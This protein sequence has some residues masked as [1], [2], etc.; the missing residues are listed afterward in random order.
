MLCFPHTSNIG[1]NFL[2][3]F[4][5]NYLDLEGIVLIKQTAFL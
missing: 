5:T 3:R 4:F 2:F 1:T